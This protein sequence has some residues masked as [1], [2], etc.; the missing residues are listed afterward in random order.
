MENK[1]TNNLRFLNKLVFET[2]RLSESQTS[3]SN[4]RVDE[5][6][7]SPERLRFYIL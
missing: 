2:A 6:H 5:K 1:T 7:F 4:R 3:I